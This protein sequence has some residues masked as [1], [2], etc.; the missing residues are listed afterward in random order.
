MKRLETIASWI[1]LGA[2]WPL[3]LGLA[4]WWGGVLLAWSEPCIAGAT[5]GGVA[6]GVVVTIVCRRRWAGSLFALG[7]GALRAVTIFY[8]V[9]VYGALMGLPVGNVFVGTAAAV[10]VGRRG[11]WRGDSAPQL[12]RDAHRWAGFVTILLALF[13]VMSAA[14]A[15]REAG[16]ASELQHMLRL[17]FVVTR[18]MVVGLIV[19]GGIGLLILQYFAARIAVR[20]GAPRP[21]TSLADEK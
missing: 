2:V 4:A 21:R 6:S 3:S 5:F 13:C 20:L 11:A 15:L 10:V 16:I 18:R 19:V 14:L 7:D 12:H 17:P 1:V 8:A 9:M